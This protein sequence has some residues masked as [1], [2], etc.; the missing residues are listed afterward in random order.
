MAVFLQSLL[1]ACMYQQENTR[2]IWKDVGGRAGRFVYFFS[3]LHLHACTEMRKSPTVVNWVQAYF[4][5]LPPCDSAF[6]SM[7][8]VTFTVSGEEY[9]RAILV[10]LSQRNCTFLRGSKISCPA[11]G[12]T[13]EQILLIKL[14]SLSPG[15]HT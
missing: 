1:S 7:A 11:V 15:S 2:K 14:Q 4:S 12:L 8:T 6:F 3:L 10:N 9:G 13:S 5:L